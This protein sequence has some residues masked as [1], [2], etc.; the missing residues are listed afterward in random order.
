MNR[1]TRLILRS[2]VVMALIALMLV[3]GGCALAGKILS[4]LSGTSWRLTA[5]SA[6]SATPLDYQITANFEGNQVGGRSAVNSYGGS[7][8][9]GPGDAFS[10]GA[11]SRTEMAGPQPAMHAEDLYFQLLGQVKRY[12]LE[13]SKLTLLDGSRNPVLIFEQAK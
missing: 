13:G 10:L 12:S 9:T 11:I 6:N 8:K 1:A 4:P 7:Y 5:W 2:A 3:L